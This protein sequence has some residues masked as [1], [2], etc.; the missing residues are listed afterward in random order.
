MADKR[1]YYEVLGVDKNATEDQIKKRVEEM[2]R[3][4]SELYEDKCPIVAAVLKGGSVF[5]TDL[6]RSM[7]CLMFFDFIS[8]SS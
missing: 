7:D 8:V 6:V 1:D 3:K 5:F 4:L 2:G